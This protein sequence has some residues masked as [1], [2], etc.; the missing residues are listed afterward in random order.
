VSI[1]SREKIPAFSWFL[2][3][4][5]VFLNP[6][7]L[8]RCGVGWRLDI[9]ICRYGL[10]GGTP[11]SR[12]PRA[13]CG[14]ALPSVVMKEAKYYG[15]QC[16][17]L[18]LRRKLHDFK[19]ACRK[20]RHP[21]APAIPPCATSPISNLPPEILVSIIQRLSPVSR[22]SLA[23]TCRAMYNLLQGDLRS[24]E[25]QY[26]TETRGDEFVPLYS[27]RWR[28]VCLLQNDKWLA[29]SSCYKLHPFTHFRPNQI[30][31]KKDRSRVCHLG[32]RGGII[33]L[34][35]CRKMSFRDK[36]R[37]VRDLE[38]QK[39]HPQEPRQP[40]TESPSGTP[41]DSDKLC[42]W[43]CCS[44]LYGDIDWETHIR[45]HITTDGHLHL[46]V[47]C[48][49][50]WTHS[51]QNSPHNALMPRGLCPH[52]LFLADALDALYYWRR[53][54][55]TVQAPVKE[56]SCYVCDTQVSVFGRKDGGTTSHRWEIDRNL[57]SI[58]G[59]P[60]ELWHSQTAS[61]WGRKFIGMYYH[62]VP[63]KVNRVRKLWQSLRRR[64][65]WMSPFDSLR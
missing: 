44:K 37:L 16:S 60:D 61:P 48:R 13:S 25:L 23:M 38:Q 54:Y 19:A 3:R 56:Y 20:V 15:S 10:P 30:L 33:D 2:G 34:C 43:H 1:F 21:N 47:S 32:R 58:S 7:T 14:P 9:I 52:R 49:A 24:K 35:P 42:S 12:G 31:F 51:P 63:P 55:T 5:P 53:G 50:R 8:G 22:A 40:L 17:A 39:Q 27:R 65:S 45:P 11:L 4:D 59:L 28:W 36:I 64:P 41:G 29:C 62:G 26:P 57:G 18:R 46:R 6:F